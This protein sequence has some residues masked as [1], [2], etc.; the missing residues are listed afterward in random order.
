MRSK[1]IGRSAAAA[2]TLAS[3][4]MVGSDPLAGSAESPYSQHDHLC[5]RA[6]TKGNFYA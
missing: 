6:H 3:G 2:W 4:A 5:L 1:P